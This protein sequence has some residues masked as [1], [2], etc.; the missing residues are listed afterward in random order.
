MDVSDDLFDQMD[1][2]KTVRKFD[3]DDIKDNMLDIGTTKG[4]SDVQSGNRNNQERD[5]G[6]IPGAL[7]GAGEQSAPEQD[8][9]GN[10]GTDESGSGPGNSGNTAT[11]NGNGNAGSRAGN[12]RGSQTGK[13]NKPAHDTRSSPGEIPAN[14]RITGKEGI[15]EGGPVQ[16]AR[17]NIDAIRL[18][19]D[20]RDSQRYPSKEEQITLSR[21]VGWG[22]TAIKNQI[23][24]ADESSL[25]GSWVG[26]RAELESLLTEDEINTAKK[27][28]NY[29]HFTSLTVV[30]KIY[31]GLKRLGFKSGAAFEG[32]VG[33]G[34]FIGRKPARMDIQFRCLHSN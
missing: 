7:S 22:D 18:A 4:N 29:A 25:S 5:E 9:T 27:S 19:I 12:A 11:T 24:P 32:G 10:A 16:K 8:A 26:M 34:N 13:G 6:G 1:D 31:E 17:Q 20:L 23:F 15:G 3:L 30:D 28:G 33:S 14:Y 21:F 2:A